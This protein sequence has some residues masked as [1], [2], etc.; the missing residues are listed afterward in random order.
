MS[1]T[2]A[3]SG[4]A[5]SH[6]KIDLDELDRK[7][8]SYLQEDG[9]ASLRKIEKHLEQKYGIKSSISA[10]KNHIERLTNQ[11]VIKDYIAVLDCCKIG[12]REMLL[13]FIKVNSSVSIKDTLCQLQTID[14]IN[15]IYQVSG[16]QPIF[17]MAK[18]VE[19]ENQIDL[20][21]KVKKIEG[22]E[23]ITT[24]VVLQ[25]VKEDMRVSIPTPH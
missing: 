14:A 19:K 16:N 1:K 17:C 9:K 11:G 20:L 15:A 3:Q 6:E 13:L 21:E 7:I 23:E 10:I 2:S 22:I 18:C 25:K 12:Y 4:K 5:I 8:L 24:Q